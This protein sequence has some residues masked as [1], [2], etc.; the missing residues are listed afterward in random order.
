MSH[1]RPPRKG[2]GSRGPGLAGS[3][4]AE[5]RSAPA[6]VILA[7]GLVGSMALGTARLA[8]ELADV[9]GLALRPESIQLRERAPW[10]A[11]EFAVGHEVSA[12]V[13]EWRSVVL[14]PGRRN[15]VFVTLALRPRKVYRASDS[16]I[17]QRG[18]RNRDAVRLEMASTSDGRLDWQLRAA[19]TARAPVVA[20]GTVGPPGSQRKDP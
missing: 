19:A 8:R 17:H 14:E 2:D 11:D 18:V 6:M 13:P 4:I 10:A 5:V 15:G 20:R 9:A 7:A 16:G 1:A 12:R 3:L